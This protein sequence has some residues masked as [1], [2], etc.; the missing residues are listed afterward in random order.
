[1]TAETRAKLS[2]LINSLEFQSDDHQAYYDRQ[3]GQIV[4]VENFIMHALESGDDLKTADLP[5]WQKEEVETARLIL[6]NNAEKR[7]IPPPDKFDFNEY[8]HMEKFIQSLEDHKAA[9]EL[10]RAIKGSGA[11]RYFKDTLYRLGLQDRWYAHRD[12]AMK[13]FVIEWCESY[14]V[15]YEDDTKA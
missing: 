10:W 7:F 3:I 11:F 4:S 5:A 14:K 13:Q 6:N 15:P 2:D 8:R 12:L 9:E 1:M